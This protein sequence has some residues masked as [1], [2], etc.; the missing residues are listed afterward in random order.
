M[1][2]ADDADQPHRYVRRRDPV[3]GEWCVD[4]GRGEWHPL[5]ARRQHDPGALMEEPDLYPTEGSDRV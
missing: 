2:M 3:L 4:C 5:H 1:I